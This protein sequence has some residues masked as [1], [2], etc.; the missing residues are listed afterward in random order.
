VTGIESINDFNKYVSDLCNLIW[1]QRI[2]D[3]RNTLPSFILQM[4]PYAPSGGGNIGIG[5]LGVGSLRSCGRQSSRFRIARHVVQ[6]CQADPE[7]AR[8]VSLSHSPGTIVMVR[9]FVQTAFAQ[10]GFAT[11][12]VAYDD[13]SLRRLQVRCDRRQGCCEWLGADRVRLVIVRAD[14]PR[15]AAT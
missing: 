2:A 14:F 11:E 10:A 9:K 5:M 4:P 7:A 13:L 1:R 3:E 12:T 6:L 15:I 8:A